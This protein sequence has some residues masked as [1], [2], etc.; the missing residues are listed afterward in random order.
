MDSAKQG[1]V[2]RS[3][4]DVYEEFFVPALFREAAQYVVRAADIRRGQSVLDVACGTGVL[5]REAAPITG[6]AREVTGLDRNEGMLAVARR[7]A[8]GIN[9]QSGLAEAL[10]FADQSFD[11][12]F[13]Q[14]GLMFF[15]DRAAA[16]REMRRVMKPGGSMHV[17]VWDALDRTPGYAAMVNLLNR[18]FGAQTADALRAPFVLGDPGT[19]RKIL[20]D[21]GLTDPRLVTFD[22]TARFPSLE[23]WVHTDIKGWTLANLIDDD[24]Y[25]TLLGEAR[26][27]LAAFERRDGSVAFTAPVRLVAISG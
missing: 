3:A 14:F 24:Q 12:V 23:A 27:E 20:A 11:R 1:Q 5:A 13:S 19:L 16:L 8:P 26:K 21:A 18:L 6:A 2:S 7:L 9:W 22:V 15:D 10:P 25:R 4:A 17:A